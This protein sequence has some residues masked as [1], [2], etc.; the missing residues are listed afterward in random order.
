MTNLIIGIILVLAAAGLFVWA[1]PGDGTSNRVPDKW[2][3]PTLLPII[4]T[5]L[6]LAG[7]LL[8][9]KSVLA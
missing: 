9:A 5:C 8:V 7:L 2:G 3:L 6:G 1:L 4:T